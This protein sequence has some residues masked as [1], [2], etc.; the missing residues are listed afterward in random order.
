[1]GLPRTL[2]PCAVA[3][4]RMKELLQLALDAAVDAG[5]SYADVRG[6]SVET[7]SLSVRGQIVES[8]DR[9]ESSGFGVRVLAGGAWGHASSSVLNEEQA[10][11]VAK[12]AV[13]VGRASASKIS[14]PVELVPEPVHVDGWSSPFE[15]DPFDVSLEEKV[16][17]LAAATSAIEAVAGVKH[18]R[19]TMDLLRQGT[20]FVSSEGSDIEQIIVHTGGGM[21]ATAVAG[22]EVQTRSYPGSDRGHYAAA[23]YELIEQMDLSGHAP[24]IAEEA[25]RL[26]AAP[27]CPSGISTLVLDGNQVMLQVHESVGHPTELDRVLGME[28]AFAGTSF[29]GLGDM[30]SLRYG[31]PLVN[32]TSDATIPGGLGTY[33]YDDEGVSGQEVDLVK[34]GILVGLQTS[35]ETA[36]TVGEGRS[37]GTMRAEGWANFPLI[38]MTNINLLPGAG[39]LEDLLADVDDGIY[40]ATNK[41]WSIDD[42]RKNF[43]FGCEIAW[44]IK[45]GKLTRIFK[46]PRYTGVT[47]A[48]WASCDAVA[49]PEEWKMWG[50]PNCGKGQPGQTM[51]VGHG[52]FPGP[53]PCG[54][55]HR[56]RS[57]SLLS[58][59]E[60][61]AAAEVV[62]DH[63]GADE[64][65]VVAEAASTA[66]TRF[67]RSEIIQNTA[68]EEVRVTVRVGV[69]GRVASASATQLD[70]K[71]LTR[72]ADNAL[73]AARAS[74][75]DPGW[76]GLPDPALV[77]RP[78]PQMRWDEATSDSSPSSRAAAVKELLAASS[79][80]NAAG[81]YGTGSHLFGIFSSKGVDCFDGY[82]RCLTTC[83]ADNG[84]STGW[85]DA[86][87]HA[88]GEVDHVAAAVR[89]RDKAEAGRGASAAAPGTYEVILEPAAT[90]LLLEYLAYVGFSAKQVVEGDSFLATRA[91][92]MVASRGISISDDVS[93]PLSVGIGFD[94][95]GVPRER[96]AVVDDGVATRP[97]TDLRT[98]S[99][100]G[101]PTSGHYSGSGETGPYA[102]NLVLDAG[103]ATPQDLV[104]E[105][106]RG[107]LVT[108]FHYVN[109]LDGPKTLLTG[110]TRDGTYLISEGEIVG[111]L[112]NLRF[113]E[114]VLGTLATT[115]GVGSDLAA[116]GPEYGSFGSTVAPTLRLGEFSFSSGTSH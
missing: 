98:G 61:R 2:F 113:A 68:R 18:G 73:A 54:S 49:G 11:R 95:E 92:D 43:Q 97:V 110:M 116:F 57:V 105:V 83:L 7:E 1:M 52:D 62:L 6:G 22:S 107:I 56:D 32:I 48:F 31:A 65:E 59:D 106:R 84:E 33:A 27:E 93:H 76:V 82:T 70:P 58:H 28:A 85:G 66:L 39:T 111:G 64:V 91:G 38:R 13:E 9:A 25:V 81:V 44:E 19:A 30:G 72:A 96:V 77:G 101:L 5:A 94:M 10:V 15:R 88:V 3:S 37:N 112:N 102:F 87:S 23:G 40:M 47:P 4:E 35:R 53:L 78:M 12:M 16:G 42:K 50:T 108:R 34:E 71:T 8:L 79:T 36:A 67:A 26:L 69:G 89:A 74:L 104:G 80:D 99:Q 60:A 41:S 103:R 109:V 17:S 14:R 86:S 63:P 100:M 114:S 75:P 21:E 51:R 20:W 55:R 115:L 29:V 46:N 90:A 45:K 24:R